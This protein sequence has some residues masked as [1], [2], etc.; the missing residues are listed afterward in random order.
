[1]LDRSSPCDP[2]QEQMSRGKVVIVPVKL[3]F[4]WQVHWFGILAEKK[5]MSE[6]DMDVRL[7]WEVCLCQLYFFI[8]FPIRPTFVVIDINRGAEWSVVPLK[9][10]WSKM[11]LCWEKKR[12]IARWR[13]R[14][15]G[16]ITLLGEEIDLKKINLQSPSLQY[17]DL[18]LH[19]LKVSL[20]HVIGWGAV[21]H[22]LHLFSLCFS[23]K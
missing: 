8:F 13:R 14:L 7:S 21:V 1:M 5:K 11:I 19:I 4:S 16:T 23:S 17:Y 22:F 2:R 18:Y 3:F 10:L 12:E 15:N 9:S 20:K 6:E